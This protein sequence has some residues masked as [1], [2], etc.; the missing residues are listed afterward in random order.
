MTFNIKSLAISEQSFV[1]LKNPATG[2][3]L[4]A[5]TEQTKPVGINVYSTGS[6]QYRSA[7]NAMQNRALKR[8]AD[9]KAKA[10]TATEMREES[11]DLLASISI[12]AENFDYEGMPLETK[13]SFRSLYMDDSLSWI[14]T[15]VDEYIGDVG[16]FI[17]A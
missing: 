3:E 13:E 12:S 4:F 15:Q 5:D 2:E 8:N 7:I 6:K 17:V 1:H 16:N 9:K 11:V 14:K 10:L